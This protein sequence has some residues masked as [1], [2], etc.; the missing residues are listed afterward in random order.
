VVDD[1]HRPVGPRV[2]PSSRVSHYFLALDVARFLPIEVFEKRLAGF[3]QTIKSSPRAL[4]EDRILV[5]GEKEFLCSRV[6]ALS[7][8]PLSENV[9]KTLC[10]VA[11]EC[12]A[13]PPVPVAG[14][15][16]EGARE[17]EGA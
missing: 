9:F 15:A 3:I 7:G 8:V 14:P 6:Q 4:G 16:A 2:K 12:G 5:A 1:V 13:A 10:K 17:G 11:E